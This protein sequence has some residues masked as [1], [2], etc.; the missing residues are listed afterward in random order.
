VI[1]TIGGASFHNFIQ[2]E[3]ALFKKKK[4]RKKEKKEKKKKELDQKC[5]CL[6]YVHGITI[7]ASNYN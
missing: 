7:F 6:K 5:R 1:A 3:T 4:E 2:M